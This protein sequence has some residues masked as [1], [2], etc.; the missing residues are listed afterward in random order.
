VK[1]WVPILILLISLAASAALSPW[2]NPWEY[3]LSALG[4]TSNGVAGAIF[5]GG[6]GATA[7]SL[8]QV[9]DKFQGLLSLIALLLALVAAVNIDFGIIHVLVATL[10]FIALY[11][12]VLAHGD[13]IA[14]LGS[15]ASIVIWASHWTLGVPPGIALPELF[16]ISLAVY[17]LLR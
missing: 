16:T 9:K 7:W 15:L 12:Y 4:S 10:L 5:D 2:W 6:L 3:S 11:A 17:Y 13:V 8:T 1:R 14:Y